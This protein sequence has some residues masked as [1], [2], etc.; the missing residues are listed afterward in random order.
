MLMMRGRSSEGVVVTIQFMGGS[1]KMSYMAG[2][3]LIL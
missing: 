3:E 1:E 2:M